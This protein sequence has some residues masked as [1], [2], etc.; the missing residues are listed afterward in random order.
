MDVIFVIGI[1]GGTIVTQTKFLASF[2]ALALNSDDSESWEFLIKKWTIVD[3][4]TGGDDP[5]ISLSGA[6]ILFIIF[7]PVC[8]PDFTNTS[9]YISYYPVACCLGALIMS[10][11]FYSIEKPEEVNPQNIP[12]ETVLQV[13]Y[14]DDFTFYFFKSDSNLAQ[15]SET[16]SAAETH[17]YS[18]TT[19]DHEASAFLTDMD[20]LWQ[21]FRNGTAAFFASI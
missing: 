5:N 20:P 21:F 1:W 10:I 2:M 11:I 15:Q 4:G 9:R 3:D 16:S 19:K 13:D 12:K 18:T 6:L 17:S 8:L 14:R 7:L